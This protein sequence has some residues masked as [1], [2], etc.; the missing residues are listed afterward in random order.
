MQPPASLDGTSAYD[1]AVRHRLFAGSGEVTCDVA[2]IG[3]PWDGGASLG[4]PGAR[5]G[6]DAVR[7]ALG[8][9]LDRIRDERVWHVDAGTVVDLSGLRLTDYGDVPLSHDAGVTF[10]RARGVIAGALE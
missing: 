1:P 2:L 3:L 9:W 4:A 8:W 5:Y 10:D 6:P 7:R